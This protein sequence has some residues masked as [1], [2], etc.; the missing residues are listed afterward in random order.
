MKVKLNCRIDGDK[1][2]IDA[3]YSSKKGMFLVSV[4]NVVT[5]KIKYT[6]SFKTI[7]EIHYWISELKRV[8]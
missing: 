6:N 1:V 8:K 3:T 4:V 2:E 7:A 5:G